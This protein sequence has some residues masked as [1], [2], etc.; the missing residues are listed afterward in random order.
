LEKAMELKQTQGVKMEFSSAIVPKK[1][2]DLV[3]SMMEY[4]FLIDTYKLLEKEVVHSDNLSTANH[5]MDMNFMAKSKTRRYLDYIFVP[6]DKYQ[7][8]RA[9]LE[10]H[11]RFCKDMHIDNKYDKF[12]GINI[13]PYISKV[14]MLTSMKSVLT[15]EPNAIFGVIKV[16]SPQPHQ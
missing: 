10:A 3:M 5:I 6:Y 7:S 14:D 8:F 2:E 9:D 4:N 1:D 11:V 12:Y 16:T 15:I 13:V